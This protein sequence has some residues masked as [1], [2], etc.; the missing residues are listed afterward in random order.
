MDEFSLFDQSRD[1]VLLYYATYDTCY[2]DTL[3]V[4]VAPL[5]CHTGV[6]FR[7]WRVPVSW[8]ALRPCW[9]PVSWIVGDRAMCRSVIEFARLMTEQAVPGSIPVHWLGLFLAITVI[10]ALVPR[11]WVESSS[12][13]ETRDVN[14]SDSGRIFKKLNPNPNPTTKPESE[15]E[16]DWF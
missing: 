8:I 15:P 6:G 2:W 5:E 14:G 10:V 1:P 9:V 7:P 11:G 3:L 16:S 13:V 12:C 4:W